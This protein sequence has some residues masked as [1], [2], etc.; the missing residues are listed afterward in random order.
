[1][2][3]A[4]ME[5]GA[6]ETAA[7]QATVG[8]E[9]VATE[10][11]V[12]ASVEAEMAAREREAA[13]AVACREAVATAAFPAAIQAALRAAL[14]TVAARRAAVGARSAARLAASAAVEA[15]AAARTGDHSSQR[16][17]S[18]FGKP[19]PGQCHRRCHCWPGSTAHQCSRWSR[20]SRA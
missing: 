16:N 12:L 10:G 14:E 17:Q 6:T 2:G 19:R 5:E 20:C 8:R 7:A 4:A 18:Q 15:W 3:A 13:Q 11:R 1:M 9:A